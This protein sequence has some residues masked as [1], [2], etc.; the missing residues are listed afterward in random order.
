MKKIVLLILVIGLSLSCFAQEKIFNYLTPGKYEVGLKVIQT[1]DY[2]RTFGPKIIDKGV[3][4]NNARPIQILVWYPSIEKGEK[5]AFK[6]YLMLGV[7]EVNFSEISESQKDRL[8]EIHKQNFQRHG[9]DLEKMN[10]IL[11]RKCFST[12]NSKAKEGKFPL[13]I[14]A[15][16]GNERCYENFMLAEYLAS[17]GY[18][19]ASIALT[20]AETQLM[21]FDKSDYERAVDDISFVI[22]QMHSFPNVDNSKLG[23]IGFCYGSMVNFTVANQNSNVDVIVDLFGA[24]NI[25]NMRDEVETYRYLNLKNPKMAYLQLAGSPEERDSYMFNHYLYGDAYQYRFKNVS[26]NA[27]TAKYVAQYHYF[28]DKLPDGQSAEYKDTTDACYKNLCQLT[29]HMLNAY[30]KNDHLALNYLN[31]NPQNIGINNVSHHIHK[32]LEVP[33]H[34]DEF[35]KIIKTEGVSKAQKI[36]NEVRS[37]DSNWKLFAENQMNFLGYQL[38]RNDQI[39]DAIVVFSMILSDHPDSWNGYDSI[40]EAYYMLGDKEK[41]ITNYKKSLELNPQN[42]NAVKMLKKIESNI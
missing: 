11:D 22:S 8:L 12:L 23:L 38:M 28:K 41:A 6:D 16:G 15:P 40:G 31:D 21:A 5:L 29:L 2:S 36:Y 3:M 33:P 10:S 39:E 37:I 25:Q 7:S 19:V 1:Y 27:F 9:A 13:I 35:I 32:A 26:H 34:Q 17:N 24:N 14:Y 4:K 20:G 42:T 30:T 18:I